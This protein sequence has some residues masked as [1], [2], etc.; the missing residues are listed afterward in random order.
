MNPLSVFQLIPFFKYIHIYIYKKR[1]K[2]N[3][4]IYILR[5]GDVYFEFLQSGS[6]IKKVKLP[7]VVK[8]HTKAPFSIATT[9]RYRGE[10]YSFLWIASFYPWNVLYNTECLA[11][12]YQVEFFESLVWLYLRLNPSLLSH[13][14][15]LYLQ[16]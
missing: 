9:L 14:W 6:L 12:R 4:Y 13:W 10:H 8:G 1:K 5:E 16:R 15:I 11:K 2:K 3:V 7:T